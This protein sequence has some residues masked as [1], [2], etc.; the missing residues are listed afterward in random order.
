M[1]HLIDR[2]EEA[3]KVPKHRQAQFGERV[4]TVLGLYWALKEMLVGLRPSQFNDEEGL[5][6]A[7][8]LY[9]Y[10]R[11][12]VELIGDEVARLRVADAGFEDRVKAAAMRVS[13]TVDKL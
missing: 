1:R 3:A 11:N 7:D 13:R 6:F 10:A 2:L 9:D 5:P 4:G 12:A 8:D